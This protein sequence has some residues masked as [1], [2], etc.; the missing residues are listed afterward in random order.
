MKQ[1]LLDNMQCP[2]PASEARCFGMQA[3]EQHLAP[4]FLKYPWY[5]VPLCTA[6]PQMKFDALWTQSAYSSVGSVVPDG[7]SPLQTYVCTVKFGALFKEKK[8]DY[9]RMLI[10][11]LS[12]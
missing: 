12:L 6:L 1:Q 8:R 4:V 3:G 11:H 7:I 10:P 5:F 2:K 9:P